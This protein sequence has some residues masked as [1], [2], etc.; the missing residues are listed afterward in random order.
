MLDLYKTILCPVDF[1]HSSDV[2]LRHAARLV[3]KV[4]ATVHLLHVIPIIPTASEIFQSLEPQADLSARRRLQKIA[5]EELP[6]IKHQIHIELAFAS[7]IPKTILATAHDVGADLIVIATHGRSGLPRLL[8]G[9]V[10]EAVVRNATCP[11][12]TVRP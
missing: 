8:L 9:S 5:D 6:V 11:V 12:L 1:D 2:S 4:N 3:A 10:T 7:D